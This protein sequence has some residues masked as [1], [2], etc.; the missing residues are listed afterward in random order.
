MTNDFFTDYFAAVHAGTVI[1]VG[2]ATAL[3]T[4]DLHYSC[5][6]NGIEDTL[7][8]TFRLKVVNQLSSFLLLIVQRALLIGKSCEQFSLEYKVKNDPVLL[9]QG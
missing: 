4:F 5:V 2:H 1:S 9:F 8:L 6:G 7:F 3:R